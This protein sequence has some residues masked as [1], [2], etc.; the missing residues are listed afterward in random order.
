MP[1]AQALRDEKQGPKVHEVRDSKTMLI[2]DGYKDID[3]G[4]SLKAEV[5]II[6][7]NTGITV[8]GCKYFVSEKGRFVKFPERS[9]KVGDEYEYHPIIEFNST[10]S[11]KGFIAQ[12]LNAID[13]YL[14]D[15]D[16]DESGGSDW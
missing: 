11:E 2:V 16:R 4:K 8:H 9:V 1:R 10:K 15:Q 12:A 13:T 14:A 3:R 7:P 6:F 5:S